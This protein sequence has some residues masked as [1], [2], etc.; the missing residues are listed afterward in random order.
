MAEIN[1]ELEPVSTAIFTE[2]ENWVSKVNSDRFVVADDDLNGLDWS[3]MPQAVGDWAVVRKDKPIQVGEYIRGQL[4]ATQNELA[5]AS[6]ASIELNL[7]LQIRDLLNRIK[8]LRKKLDTE[9]MA[10]F[11]A[12]L[13]NGD[14]DTAKQIIDLHYLENPLFTS[15][16][17]QK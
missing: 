7:N 8:A 6:S 11:K 9:N 2:V 4:F 16:Y 13:S 14:Y 15:D 5:R 3:T 1:H 17:G 12:I 10:Q